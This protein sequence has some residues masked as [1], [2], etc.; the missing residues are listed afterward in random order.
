M[1]TLNATHDPKRRSFIESANQADSD[2][3]IQNL[4][5]CVFRRGGSDNPRGGIAIGDQIFDLAAAAAVSAQASRPALPVN[6]LALPAFTTTVRALPPFSDARH[7]SIGAPGHLLEVKTAATV[8]LAATSI[9][10]TSV[11]S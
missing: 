9:S 4:P 1:I 2:F 5:L 10:T 6:T 3:P 7:Q 11:R 8:L